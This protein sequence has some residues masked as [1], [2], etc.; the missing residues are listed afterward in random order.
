MKDK[1]SQFFKQRKATKKEASSPQEETD[2]NYFKAARAWSDDINTVTLISRNRY[3]TAF[4][5]AFGLCALLVICVTT[6]VP[7]QHTELVVVHEGPSGYN[8]ISTTKKY[9]QLQPNWVRTK[10]EI[11]N[12]VVA[13]E[14]YDPLLYRY[15]TNQVKV[16]S[17]PQVQAEYELAQSSDNKAAPINVLGAKGY[18]TVIINSV[19]PLDS[20][21]KN[22]NGVKKHVNLAQVNYVIVD[23][24]FGQNQT[25]KTPYTA[26]VSWQYNGT[27]KDPAKMITDWDGFQITKFIAQPVNVGNNN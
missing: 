11:A 1:L 19:L 8:W 22:K 14:S 9:G 3:K 18:R 25:I 20:K 7:L 15:Q 16:L 17:T 27:P 5:A 2:S 10:S 4:F 12:Y 24:L 26:L 13:R 21:S 6:L 23:H